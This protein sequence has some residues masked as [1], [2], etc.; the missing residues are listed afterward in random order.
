MQNVGRKSLP[1]NWSLFVFPP[2][3]SCIHLLLLS[4]H[5]PC[6]SLAS[7]CLREWLSCDSKAVIKRERERCGGECSG[8]CWGSQSSFHP[9]S[10]LSNPPKHTHTHSLSSPAFSPFFIPPF[11]CTVGWILFTPLSTAVHPHLFPSFSLNRATHSLSPTHIQHR[12]NF[13]P[14]HSS[15]DQPFKNSD[16]DPLAF[17]DESFWDSRFSTG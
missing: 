5:P 16:P 6:S 11:V 14:Y 13:A 2:F 4:T 3:S 9:K 10:Y 12:G 8:I 15:T 1:N 7:R 17:D